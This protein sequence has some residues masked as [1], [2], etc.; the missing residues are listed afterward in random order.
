[1]V[2]PHAFIIPTTVNQ[3]IFVVKIF[4]TVT[5][6]WQKYVVSKFWL[7]WFTVWNTIVVE[8]II[9]GHQNKTMHA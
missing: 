7:T 5:I 6:L 4:V 2:R 1:M 9:T 8:A 3:E